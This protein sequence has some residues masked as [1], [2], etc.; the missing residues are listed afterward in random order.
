MPF[1]SSR[2]V[3]PSLCRPQPSCRGCILHCVT[4]SWHA[5]LCDAGAAWGLA[6]HRCSWVSPTLQRCGCKEAPGRYLVATITKTR[7]QLDATGG[8]GL[9]TQG[10]NKESGSRRT[11]GDRQSSASHGGPCRVIPIKCQEPA[12]WWRHRRGGTQWA[13]RVL[14]QKEWEACR[15]IHCATSGRNVGH[16]SLL[17]LVDRLLWLGTWLR[18]WCNC[19][20]VISGCGA[21]GSWLGTER[22]GWLTLPSG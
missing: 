3:P 11:D 14:N 21:W 13:Q 7:R 12:P 16:G 19:H 17:Q 4:R 15:R 5:V 10:H 18:A 20:T 8:D 6:P 22:C 1:G 2:V 9:A